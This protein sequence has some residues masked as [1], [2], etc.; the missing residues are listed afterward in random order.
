MYNDDLQII[1]YY[2][3]FDNKT[4]RRTFW[5]KEIIRNEHINFL[6]LAPGYNFVGFRYPEFR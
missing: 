1:C 5:I 4:L 2:K 6:D 3:N